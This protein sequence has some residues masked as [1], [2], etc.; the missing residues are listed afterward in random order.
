MSHNKVTKKEI[1]QVF[2]RSHLIQA[3]WN[4]EGQMNLGYLYAI[5]PVLMRLYKDKKQLSKAMERQLALF[6]TT[7][8]VAT[9]IMGINITMEEQASKDTSF[10]TESI[11]AVKTSLM[12]PLAGIGDSFFWGTFKVIA[13]GIG[14]G[15]ATQGS[16]VGPIASIVVY[17]IPS[18][19]TRYFGLHIGY[20][21]GN[22]FLEK[23]SGGLMEKVTYMASIVGLMVVGCMVATLIDLNFALELTI[24]GQDSIT[25]QGILDSF[26]PQAT[27]LIATAILY[28][29]VRKVTSSTK[30]LIGIILFSILSAYLKVFII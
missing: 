23:M 13:A 8:Q 7:P 14:I 12:G 10:P 5:L 24:S 9:F 6:N 29:L 25:L 16:I 15:F 27:P 11:N 2:L 28:T 3:S 17:N 18:I 21:M 22:T 30:L 20:K 4:Y 26:L 19:L 1:N